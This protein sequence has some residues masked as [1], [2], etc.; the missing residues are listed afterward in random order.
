MTVCS[1]RPNSNRGPGLRKLAARTF[2]KGERTLAQANRIAESL[3]RVL[4]RTQP[5]E[6]LPGLA[7]E[8]FYKA[9]LDEANVGGDSFDAFALD[10]D[11]VA[12]VV[13]DA[14][15]KGL[16]AAERV[17]EVRF[18]IRAFLREH[19]D[20]CRAVSC[21]NEFVCDSERLGRRDVGTFTTLTLVVLD[22]FSGEASCLCAG[23]EPPLVLRADRSV[24][25]V[26]I[27]GPALGLFQNQGYTAARLRLGEGDIVLLT[28]DGITEA[29][30]PVSDESRSAG[31]FLGMEGLARLA[32][33]A[34]EVITTHEAISLSVF[35]RSIIEGALTFAGGSF[36]DDV[37]LLI[38]KIVN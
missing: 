26:P 28:T 8:A 19:R 11:K 14:S 21:L 34:H 35:V 32:F 3:Q 7:T 12:L 25:V 22:C 4:L 23:G 5:G 31:S 6:A 10:G 29:R 16:A 9:A 13:A 1:K 15:G 20:P 37:C 36:H 2:Y 38:G 17:A 18:A 24:E 30:I 33:Q 27:C